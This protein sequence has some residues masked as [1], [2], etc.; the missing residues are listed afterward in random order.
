MIDGHT[1]SDGDDVVADDDEDNDV[2]DNVCS[3]S[4]H[5]KFQLETVFLMFWMSDWMVLWNVERHDVERLDV[6]GPK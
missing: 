6:D 1:D 3:S 4:R 5:K 2:D